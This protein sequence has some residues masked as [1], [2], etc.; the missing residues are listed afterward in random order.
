[1]NAETEIEKK[2]IEIRAIGHK[3]IIRLARKVLATYVKPHTFHMAMG[4]YVFSN[5]Y[6]D[7]IYQD[8]YTKEIEDF[9]CD[10]D[11]MFNFTG[12]A[13]MIYKDGSIDKEYGNE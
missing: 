5:E 3:E 4:T 6:G 1:M 8:E 10:L 7:S 13:I 11:L 2:I 12:C 9:L